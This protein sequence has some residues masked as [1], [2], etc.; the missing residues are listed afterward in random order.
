MTPGIAKKVVL[1]YAVVERECQT[2][3]LASQVPSTEVCLS[4]KP[5]LETEA[6][7]WRRSWTPFAVRDVA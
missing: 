2:R 5:F 4:V 6:M 3:V 7:V 1:N